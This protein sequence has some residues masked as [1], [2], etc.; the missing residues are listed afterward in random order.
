MAS[1]TFQRI[2]NRDFTRSTVAFAWRSIDLIRRTPTRNFVILVKGNAVGGT[3]SDNRYPGCAC[4]AWRGL[5]SFSFEQRPDWTRKYPGQEELLVMA[6]HNDIPQDEYLTGVAENY[7][8]YRYIRFSSTVKEARWDGHYLQWKVKV[9]VVGAKESEYQDEYELTTDF[10][11]SAVGQLNEPSYPNI[12]GLESF[13]GEMMHSARWD[14][15]YDFQDKRIGVIGNGATAVQ[16]IPELA[17]TASNLTVY[18]RTPNWIIARNDRTVSALHKF[19]LSYIPPVQWCKRALLMQLTEC[20]HDAA[21]NR[22]S[23]LGQKILCWAQSNMKSQFTDKPELWEV[24]TPG[25]PI[26]CKRLL[27]TDDYFPALNAEHVDLETRQIRQVTS[28]GI[29]TEDGA[30]RDFDLIVLATGFCS[31][32]FLHHVRIYG[33][34]GCS[35]ESI[36]KEGVTAYC[37]VTVESPPNFGMLYGPNTNLGYTSVILM[38]EA[39]SR[40]LSTLVGAVIQAKQKGQ[41]LALQP[42]SDVVRE[43]DDRIQ[44][45]LARIKFADLGCRSWYKADDGR[46]TNNWPGMALEYQKEMSQVRWTDYHVQGSGQAALQKRKPT[47]IGCPW[48]MPP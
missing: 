8:L 46:I 45:R 23:K 2:G 36:W 19:L 5:Y 37:G 10:L 26:G 38:I 20:F 17:K 14:W 34:N 6:P 21:M 3:W 35:L 39:Q 24:L 30:Q 28:T 12:P 41:K 16:V 1:D 29:Q 9:A 27:A 47:Y 25:Y 11:V 4:D 7:G 48:A 22:D 33:A 40:C 13:S 42:R 44:E 15:R 18:Q 31:V 43:Y 32:E